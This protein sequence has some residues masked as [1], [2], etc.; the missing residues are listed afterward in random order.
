MR[1]FTGLSVLATLFVTLAL[2][3]TPLAAGR[4][5]PSFTEDELAFLDEIDDSYAWSVTEHLVDAGRVVE[6]TA[7]SYDTAVWIKDQLVDVCGLD[8]ANVV[9][10]AFPVISY[11]VDEE[12]AGDSVGYTSL[13]LKSGE[14]WA[15]IPAA[16]AHEGNGTGPSGVTAQIVDLGDGKIE[17][18]E[19]AGAENIAGKIVLFSRTDVMFYGTPV[20]HMA[21][22]RG[23][24][25]AIVHFPV[26]PDDVLKIDVSDEVLPMVYISNNGAA[27][28]RSLMAEGPVTAKLI[29]DNHW[30]GEP[31]STGHNVLGVIPGTDHP[32]EYVYLGAHLDHWFTSAAD[33][34]AGV[35]SL[36]AIAKA[37]V[38]SGIKPKRTLVFAVWDAE[39]MGGW[40]D[41]WY[42]WT[43]GSYSHIVRTL[44]GMPG[45]HSDRVGKITA[46]LNM[47]VIAA[48]G[49]VVF[50][51]TTP[52]MTRFIRRV[53]SDSG[54]VATVPTFVYW[55][56]SSYDDWP[57]Y[58]AGVPVM[59]I[60]FWGPAYDN[61]YH[62]TGDTM[63]KIN[64]LYLHANVVFNGLAAIRMSQAVVLPYNLDE[65]IEV[66]EED[67]AVL[68]SRDPEAMTRVDLSGLSAGLEAYEAQ[69]DRID[70]LLSK[71]R[72]MTV[73][74][75]LLNGK[76]MQSAAALNPIL[77]DWDFTAWIP[78]WTGVS[79]LDNPSNDLHHLKAAIDALAQADGATALYMLERITTM[80]WGMYVDY[81]AYT[82]VLDTIYYVEPA[83][84][85]WGEGFLPPLS[86]VH[87][88]YF[89]ILEKTAH[90]QSDFSAEITALGQRVEDLYAEMDGIAD[91]LGE[92]LADA[93]EIL[94]DVR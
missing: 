56:P 10:E 55:P 11:D 30:D 85:L 19:R 64:P 60:A 88:E 58:M 37:I 77:F 2:A 69:V 78:G 53:A 67:L 65:N 12:L 3:A 52:D 9:L 87:Q 6:G 73:D 63:D 14:A 1:A 70:A 33:D 7:K 46:M 49:T 71:K 47:D 28:I 34:N 35:G 45:L 36:L 90:G 13:E 20:L 40:A 91:E 8:P 86:D 25:A 83:H 38:D 74:V 4:P 21:A 18:F 54:L 5:S 57:F 75:D 22:Q 93:A 41:T 24:V 27:E 44:D 81:E 76:M 89:S 23:A 26:V 50:I 72:K 31:A 48:D 84:L 66:V 79:V 15:S 59:Q 16:Q 17:D 51:E 32:D 43:I 82:S 42:D 62:T 39:E 92:A 94:A 29:V 61:L 68:A 80:G